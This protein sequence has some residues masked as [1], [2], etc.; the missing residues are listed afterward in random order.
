MIYSDN[1]Y[2]DILV[3]YT[4]KLTVESIIKDE[5][6]ADLNETVDSR[7]ASLVYVNSTLQNTLPEDYEYE[8]TNSYYRLLA[9]LP[10]IPNEDEKIE[11][12][13]MFPNRNPDMR[14]WIPIASYRQSIEDA[15]VKIEGVYP[16]YL[17]EASLPLVSA[18]QV[19]GVLDMI[20]MNYSDSH[21]R[22]IDHIGEKRID[23]LT[24][25]MASKFQLLYIP[26]VDYS[27]IKQRYEYIYEKN[28]LYVLR[29]VYSDAFKVGNSYYDKFIILLIKVMTMMD[30]ITDVY[31][32]LIHTEVFDSRT[33]R[34]LFE[35]Y[36]VDY[37][38]EIPTKYQIA[39]LKNMNTLLKYKS[40]NRN[41][42]DICSLFGCENVQVF[43]YYIM[44]ER[45]SD[46][47]IFTENGREDQVKNYTLKFIKVPLQESLDNYI[48][49][50][51]HRI[52]YED[53]TSQDPFWYGLDATDLKNL[54]YDDI[55]RYIA[56]KKREILEK[57]F[58]YERTKYISIDSTYDLAKMS[59]QITYFYNMIFD[60]IPDEIYIDLP[61]MAS[62]VEL[63]HVFAYILALGYIYNGIEDDI[64]TNDMEKNMYIYGF[65][66]EQ[67]MSKLYTDLAN[68]H[69]IDTTKEGFLTEL[70][71]GREFL[72]QASE[73]IMDLLPYDRF[74]TVLEN[75]LKIEEYLSEILYEESDK[76]TYD[77]YELLYK[78]LMV[79]KF[80]TKYFEY[81][82]GEDEEPRCHRTYTEFLMMN[83]PDLYKS[84]EE[85]KSI[86]NDEKRRVYISDILDIVIAKLEDLFNGDESKFDFSYIYNI[87]PTRNLS[88]LTQCIIKVVNFFKSY[89]TQMIG[90]STIYTMDDKLNNKISFLEKILMNSLYDFYNKI[91]PTD[92]AGLISR[93][94]IKDHIGI[95]ED[96]D[97]YLDEKIGPDDFIVA[98]DVDS[99]TMI[100]ARSVSTKDI[101]LPIDYPEGTVTKIDSKGLQEL[102]FNSI[103]IPEG[104]EEIL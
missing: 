102:N 24:A 66:F 8:E 12:L 72:S 15:G 61:G 16:D 101:V 65:N 59:Q 56:K 31:D 55:S 92:Y 78:S 40:T 38:S 37:Y 34:F 20:K 76:D 54:N 26:D 88:F 22:Y 69:N 48:Q 28:R 57:E 103:E 73:S 60:N 32:Y 53:V 62:N 80:S 45:V 98:Y 27:E 18:M 39:M 91:E 96:V 86:T 36:G 64:I 63:G 94:T 23:P 89:K 46:E 85:C 9:G 3:H 14:Y 71:G 35:S 84:L 43:K 50:Q 1:P 93:I 19:S 49:S 47:L 51:E 87:V 17:H 11:Y 10:P 82:T 100:S 97:E 52:S 99:L 75:N 21:Y 90:F 42:V 13:S 95:F 74:V 4:K 68:K 29:C 70:L 79:K 25:R 30:M 33:I 77:L 44:K 7:H 5:T 81:T 41:I 6:E 2:I 67:D 58:S 104:V 83:E